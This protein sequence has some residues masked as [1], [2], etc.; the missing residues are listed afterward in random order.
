MSEVFIGLEKKKKKREITDRRAND[1]LIMKPFLLF[2]LLDRERAFIFED[3]SHHT[4][5]SIYK[6]M[7]RFFSKSV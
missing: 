1:Q 7:S 3:G 5:L 6:T 4:R 2:S